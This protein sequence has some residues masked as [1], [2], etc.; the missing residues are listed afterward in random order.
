MRRTWW[1]CTDVKLWWKFGIKT[2]MSNSISLPI[3]KVI[4]AGNMTN[5]IGYRRGNEYTR[6]SLWLFIHW[7]SSIHS[8]RLSN[9]LR[10]RKSLG[11]YQLNELLGK[12][13]E[14]CVESIKFTSSYPNLVKAS[15]LYE[16]LGIRKLWTTSAISGYR[17]EVYQLNHKKEQLNFCAQGMSE[18]F[19]STVILKFLSDLL[20][21]SMFICTVYHSSKIDLHFDLICSYYF[22]LFLWSISVNTMTVK[23]Y[24]LSGWVLYPPPPHFLFV[25]Y[26]AF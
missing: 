5:K 11:H 10:N 9:Y 25:L 24:R 4:W 20:I 8:H 6:S 22:W 2:A 17:S 13:P 14:Y 3:R 7:T 12:G 19:P 23:V 21:L 15:N 16:I 18:L 1:I 26:R